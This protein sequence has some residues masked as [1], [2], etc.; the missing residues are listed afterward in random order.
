MRCDFPVFESLTYGRAERRTVSVLSDSTSSIRSPVYKLVS[1][2]SALAGIIAAS[3]SFKV[4]SSTH[5]LRTISPPVYSPES[6]NP[7][8]LHPYYTTTYSF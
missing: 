8:W 4:S 7:L 1:I 2:A 5:S 6:V 3:T